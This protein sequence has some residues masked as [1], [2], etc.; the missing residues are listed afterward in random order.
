MYRLKP[1]KTSA[2][3]ASEKS[4]VELRS[5]SAANAHPRGVRGVIVPNQFSS[6]YLSG[7]SRPHTCILAAWLNRLRKSQKQI[8]CRPKGLLVMT[9]LEGL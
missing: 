6:R 2:N 7:E 9:N 4:S 3:Q 1:L 5:K 8:P